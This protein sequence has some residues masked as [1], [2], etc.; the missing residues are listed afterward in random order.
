M[1]TQLNFLKGQWSVVSQDI[2]KAIQSFF[3]YVFLPKGLNTTILALIP[4][5][6]DAREMK[7]YR[8]ISCCNVLYK[9]ISKIWRIELKSSFRV[10][11]L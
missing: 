8:P 5:K 4:K 2:T 9:A 10:S 1:G 3:I 6:K 7:N 11:F